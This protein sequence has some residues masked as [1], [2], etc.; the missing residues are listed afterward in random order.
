MTKL[1]Y[2]FVDIS[3]DI[4]HFIDSVKNV[5]PRKASFALFS[6]IQFVTSLPAIKKSLEEFGFKITIPQRMP[7]SPGELLGCT[8]PRVLHFV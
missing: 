4:A 5:F 2:V 8:S 1:R 3:F 7:L 6:T